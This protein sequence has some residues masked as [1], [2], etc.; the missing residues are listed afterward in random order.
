MNIIEHLKSLPLPEHARDH[1]LKIEDSL[2]DIELTMAD[3]GTLEQYLKLHHAAMIAYEQ[4]E[5][6]NFM[7]GDRRHPA[8]DV[9]INSVKEQKQLASSLGLNPKS[10]LT[11]KNLG[12]EKLN[13]DTDPLLQLFNE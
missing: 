3:A 1:L 5:S 10:R 2:A 8:F 12:G 9:Y 13:A 11:L 6:S 4:A 7:L